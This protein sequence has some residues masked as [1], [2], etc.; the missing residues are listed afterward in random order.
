MGNSSNGIG[1]NS[2]K[3]K[4]CRDLP[5]VIRGTEREVGPG[6]AG[7]AGRG[8]RSNNGVGQGGCRT[9]RE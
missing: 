1:L 2:A 3:I 7:K 4:D 9:S 6:K 5:V 8:R